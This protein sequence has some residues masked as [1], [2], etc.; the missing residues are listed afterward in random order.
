MGIFSKRVNSTTPKT[1]YRG[2]NWRGV[3]ISFAK[4]KGNYKLISSLV[5][6]IESLLN[7]KDKV[8]HVANVVYLGTCLNCQ[9][10]YVGET[11]R[12]FEIREAEHEDPN[13]NSKP[14]RHIAQNKDHE[15]VWKTLDSAPH[16]KTRKF[17]EAIYIANLNQHLTN[18][19]SLFEP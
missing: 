2:G 16:W 3:R 10:N 11:C 13:Y 4:I 1:I 14:A 9:V 15:F 6:K 17:K 19:L 12:N 7:L 18:K 5:E 8:K